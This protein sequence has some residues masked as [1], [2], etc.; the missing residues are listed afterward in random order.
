[1]IGQYEQAAR[2]DS[3]FTG[4]LARIGYAYALFLD[5]GWDFPGLTRDSMLARGFAVADRALALDS[6]AADAWM[7]RGYLLSFRYPRTFDGVNA[8]FDRAIALDPRNPEAHHQYGY[9][10]MTA[11]D[12]ARGRLELERALALEPERAITLVTLATAQRLA[13]HNEAA[14]RLLDS[15]LAVDPSA[16]YAYAH[17]SLWRLAGDVAGAQADA[18]AAA[19]QCSTD[20]L[21][22]AEAALA[23]AEFHAGDAAA[24]R[25]RIEPL[26]R[27]SAARG[28]QGGYTTAEAFA[29]TGDRERAL[30]VLERIEPRGAV[31]WWFM[32][33][34]WFDAIRTD[35]RF[36]RLVEESRPPGR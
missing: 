17:R 26:F 3:A 5:W 25:A 20:C 22:Q 24:A 29:V 2:I 14:R 23:A 4:A 18:E 30:A 1:L 28:M 15:A 19:R 7:A 36:R 16:A 11:G 33:D 27:S 32:R 34:P 13:D 31:L 12:D 21:T 9:L 35:P 10:L 6:S 8:A